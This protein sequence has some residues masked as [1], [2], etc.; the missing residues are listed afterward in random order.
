MRKDLGNTKA[1]HSNASCGSFAPRIGAVPQRRR[2][3]ASV[4]QGRELVIVA[5]GAENRTRRAR[6]SARASA[7][8]SGVGSSV[9][10]WLNTT[11]ATA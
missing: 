11:A 4:Y 8:R 5:G 2:R 9:V 3:R 10:G 7:A 6:L 1:T